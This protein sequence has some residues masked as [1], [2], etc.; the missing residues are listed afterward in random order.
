MKDFKLPSD[1]K[2]NRGPIE[3][4]ENYLNESGC[5]SWLCLVGEEFAEM[6]GGMS[7]DQV[8]KATPDA[9]N[10]VS[11][12]PRTLNLELARQHVE[13]LDNLPRPTLVSCR[14]GPRAS[15]VA[16]MYAGLK[17]NADP[18]AVLKAAEDDEAP[19]MKFEDYK[20]WVRKSIETLRSE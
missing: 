14:T 10:V 15:A 13:A 3:N 8:Q 11:D 12:P 1:L 19:F 7:F 17:E 5:V 9:I 20:D 16:Y 6:Q 2:F 4:P 18:E